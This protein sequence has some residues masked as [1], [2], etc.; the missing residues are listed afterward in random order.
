MAKTFSIDRILHGE[1]HTQ[2]TAS[3]DSLSTVQKPAIEYTQSE[4]EL[5][6]LHG[7]E[8]TQDTASSD[9]LST[10][11]KPAIEYTQSELELM[12]QMAAAAYYPTASL[13]SWH[14]VQSQALPLWHH[15]QGKQLPGQHF[16]LSSLAAVHQQQQSAAMLASSQAGFPFSWI[17]AVNPSDFTFFHGIYPY[18]HSAF[19]SRSM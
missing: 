17:P 15:Q 18:T 9:S 14:S 7:E 19:L 8:H 4:L 12:N 5:I 1:E 6:S 16:D 2:D 11:Q 13:L 10:V 3:S